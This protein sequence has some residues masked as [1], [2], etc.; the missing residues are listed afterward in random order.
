MNTQSLR[1]SY[2]AL[3]FAIASAMIIAPFSASAAALTATASYPGTTNV[4][5]VVGDGAPGFAAGSIAAD[6]LGKSEF[7]FYPAQLFGKE[8]TLGEIE[9]ISYWTKKGDL[10]TVNPAD[11]FVNLYTKPYV[12][13]VSSASWY[14]ER[15]GTE[16]YLSAALNAPINTWNNWTTD[17]SE[18]KL[19][20]FESTAGAPGANFGSY[21]DPDWSTFVAGNSLSGASYA[22]REL[23]SVSVQTGSAWADGFFGQV[24][25]LTVTLTDNT[26]GSVNFEAEIPFEASIVITDP[27][28]N[29]VVSGVVNFAATYTDE[30]GDDAVQW[31]V[32][33][34][35]CTSGTVA[36]NVDGYTT[37]FDWD[38]ETFTA[39]IDMSSL[40]PGEY[41]F[42]VNPTEDAGDENLRATQNFTLEAPAD[43]EPETPDSKLA[44]MKGGWEDFGF[45]NQGQCVR[46]VET[47]KDSR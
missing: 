42:V 26:V 16:P 22:S 2:G 21:V 45:K 13:D 28:A 11:W 46:F 36:G 41:C 8:V 4:V 1:L 43:P 15:I 34:G 14:G 37:D 19:R 33:A 27:S 44:C 35:S 7:Y 32:R 38:G 12:G 31:A 47:G 25:G 17:G 30:D 18:N 23:L 29:E 9:S 3:A 5:E 40:T 6:G 20:F 10:H 24:D 39:S